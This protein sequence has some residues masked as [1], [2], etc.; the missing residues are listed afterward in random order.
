[1]SLN[2]WQ[3][4]WVV[5][6]ALWLIGSGVL[7]VAL[8]LDDPA[9]RPEWRYVGSILLLW[10]LPPLLLYALGVAAGWVY[11]GFAVR[12]KASRP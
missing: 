1:M 10:L 11:R 4:L 8:T 3:R 12:Q 6:S 2:G 5:V 9:W 7:I